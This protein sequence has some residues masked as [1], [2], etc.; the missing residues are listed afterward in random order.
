MSAIE[1][2]VARE[3]IDSRGNPTVEADVLLS[4][5]SFGRASV[6][7]GAST[8]RFEALELR[9]KD[10]K[11]YKGQGVLKAVKNINT[12]IAPALSGKNA[13]DQELIDQEMITLDG[14]ENKTNL[15]ANSILAVSMAVTK[16]AAASQNLPLYKYIHTI[17]NMEISM[18]LPVPLMNIINGGRHAYNLLDFQEFMIVPAGAATFSEALRWGSEIFHTLKDILKNKKMVTSVGDEGGFAPTIDDS[19]QALNLIIEA[20]NKAGYKAGK[21]I[22]I[23]LDIA[24]SEF[25]KDN[26]YFLKG[27][28]E[29][30]SSEP[31]ADYITKLT[32]RFPII[33]V[34]D[35][36]DQEDWMAWQDFT[37]NH[38]TALQIVG[39][40][41]FVTNVNRF[42]KG[43]DLIG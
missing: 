33:S 39:D 23:A 30:F 4:D 29:T 19:V 34:E 13:L 7:S 40:D 41:L 14:T 5:G 43:I 16:A 15:G 36:F 35:P 24:A 10:Q 26:M 37:K 27:T 6:P 42:Q 22:F 8:G 20:I 2:I 25:F 21:Q 38:K 12:L 18:R 9:D 31:F 1:K 17:F 11:R 32:N 28:K 3:I